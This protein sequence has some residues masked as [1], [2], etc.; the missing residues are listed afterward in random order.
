MRFWVWY[1]PFNDKFKALRKMPKEL[2]FR[3]E[4]EQEQIPEEYRESPLDIF[5]GGL[6]GT[7]P[8]YYNWKVIHLWW[9]DNGNSWKYD[10]YWCDNPV[11]GNLPHSQY[12]D[13]L[14]EVGELPNWTP[15]EPFRLLLQVALMDPYNEYDEIR[16]FMK[17]HGL[18]VNQE[19][20]SWTK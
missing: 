5:I 16:E 6:D 1:S 12:M 7:N 11:D 13:T 10:L 20:P 3:V 4:Y 14:K 2:R 19:P 17:E 15:P 18:H 9:S 8:E